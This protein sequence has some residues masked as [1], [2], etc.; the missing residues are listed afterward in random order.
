MSLSNIQRS[1]RSSRSFLRNL[2]DRLR[3]KSYRK[4]FKKTPRNFTFD[5]DQFTGEKKREGFSLKWLF[6]V[7]L[8]LMIGFGG[9]MLVALIGVILFFLHGVKMLWE[10]H[11]RSSKKF[12][13]HKVTLR[14]REKS[15]F[16][17]NI[18]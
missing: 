11:G 2:S 15:K 8:A 6:I 16:M 4:V 3:S 10:G 18:L 7:P 14:P 9:L 13:F 17:V 12:K 5:H 1:L